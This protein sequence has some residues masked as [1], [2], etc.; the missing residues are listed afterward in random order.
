MTRDADLTPEAVSPDWPYPTQVVIALQQY[1]G[2]PPLA[3]TV[4]LDVFVWVWL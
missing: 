3:S 1:A 2:V 4:D